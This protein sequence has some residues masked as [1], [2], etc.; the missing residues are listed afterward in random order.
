MSRIEKSY[1]IHP[2]GSMPLLV[3][4]R[5]GQRF[6]VL[7]AV[8]RLGRANESITESAHALEHYVVDGTAKY[9][10]R[11]GV[12]S[13]I[14]D[15]GGVLRAET[16]DAI[17]AFTVVVPRTHLKLG[18]DV[19]TQL[20]FAPRLLPRRLSNVRKAIKV[21]LERRASD[22]SYRI[23]SLFSRALF[24]KD[25]YGFRPDVHT[26]LKAVA[27]I[28][29]PDLL[30]L[31][32]HAYHPNN[33]V[34]G[35]IGDLSARSLQKSLRAA[36]KDAK[37]QAELTTSLRSSARCNVATLRLAGNRHAALIRIGTS[38][39]RLSEKEYFAAIV[40]QSILGGQ[41]GARL[42]SSLR[43]KQKLSYSTGASMHGLGNGLITFYAYADS[44]AGNIQKVIKAATQVLYNSR[45]RG[46]SAK[47][48]RTAIKSITGR[49]LCRDSARQELLGLM[50]DYVIWNRVMDTSTRV[51]KL[52]AITKDQCSAVLKKLLPAD[53]KFLS[54]AIVGGKSKK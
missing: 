31:Y 32:K 6:V 22:D 19:L 7:S 30:K 33:I 35:A 23:S 17:T 12:Y 53:P 27:T 50:Y 47:E 29:R 28:K 9:P 16:Y 5:P 14:T 26:R 18:V 11:E 41:P 54:M 51:S 45:K 4:K 36:I 10:S 40:A 21:E 42:N 15:V 43:N 1:V 48:V 46:F 8:I 44:S 25:S 13:A 38:T 24:S 3:M 49:M 20:L 34:F 2:T 39:Q 37:P 52:R